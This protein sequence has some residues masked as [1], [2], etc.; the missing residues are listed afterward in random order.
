[1]PEE[2]RT[3]DVGRLNAFSDGVMVVSMTLLVLDVRLPDTVASIDGPQLLHALAELWPKYFGYAVSFLVIARYWM[4]Y[5]EKFGGMRAVDNG[6]VW[7]NIF[8]LLAVGF[9]PF[10]TSVVSQN[11]GWVATTLY[12]VTMVVVVSLLIAM[13]F[14]AAGKGLVDCS[15]PP[16]QQWREVVPW[17]QIA[18][19]FS[20]SIVVAQYDPRFAK[21]VWLLLALPTRKTVAPKTMPP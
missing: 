1:M 9:I 20:V 11:H 8:F 5:T 18:V 16:R 17:I 13:W 14:Y 19:V 10:V 15:W 2:R 7:L 6:F 3:R 21:L 4:G 12:A